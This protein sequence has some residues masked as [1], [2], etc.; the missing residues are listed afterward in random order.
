[1]PHQTNYL[2][3]YSKKRPKKMMKFRF[4]YHEVSSNAA[5]NKDGLNDSDDSA[6]SVQ[7]KFEK[8][9]PIP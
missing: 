8:E 6:G 9:A 4:E 5:C 1:M 3:P 7:H 2:P